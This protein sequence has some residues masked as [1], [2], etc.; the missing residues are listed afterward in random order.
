M[1]VHLK[2][3]LESFLLLQWTD[4]ELKHL[5]KDGE[6]TLQVQKSPFPEILIPDS[7]TPLQALEKQSC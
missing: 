1:F 2:D 7:W 4:P 5:E 3:K 6:G